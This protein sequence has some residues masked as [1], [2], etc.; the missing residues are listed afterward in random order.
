MSAQRFPHKN[1]E[2]NFVKLTGL[3]TGVANTLFICMM[4]LFTSSFFF[5]VSG[6]SVIK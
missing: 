5:D 6:L 2:I 3:P 4:K 1:C